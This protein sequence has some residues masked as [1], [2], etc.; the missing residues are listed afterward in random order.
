EVQYFYQNI[1]SE[2]KAP[3]RLEIYNEQ[4]FRDLSKYRMHWTLLRNGEWQ[5]EGT[6]DDVNVAPQDRRLIDV[7]YGDIDGSAEWLLN[8]SFRLKEADGLLE[9]DFEVARQ[10]LALNDF[11]WTMQPLKSASR[12]KIRNNAAHQFTV[13][14]SNFEIDF[15]VDDGSITRWQVGGVSLLKSGETLRPNFWRAPTDNDFGAGL[16]KK[17]AFWKKPKLYYYSLSQYDKNNLQVIIIEYKLEGSDARVLME[18]RVNDQGSM[19]IVE[20]LIPGK[21]RDLPGLF[22]FGV[23]I[24]LPKSFEN[25]EYYGRGPF[26][27]YADRK[28]ASFL[29]RWTQTVSEQYYPYI[30]PQ[31]TG[32]RTDLRW[33]RIT[34]QRGKGLEIQA[35]EPFSASA[36]HYRIETLDDGEFKHNRHSEF[37]KEDDV[38]NLLLDWRQMGLG[39]ITSWGAVPLPEYHL[40]YGEYRFHFIL[41]PI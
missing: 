35:E 36:L 13:S 8:L 41:K 22:R 38:T 20:Q 19:E 14:G 31:E 21:N 40:P 11:V 28:A 23:Q 32:T 15:S 18:Y 2:L 3:N 34:N 12:P 30:K 27:N 24:P 9:K 5:A 26:E 37:L 1:W 25:L 33:L 17:M 16:Q 4:F 29:G 7:P 10:Q 6:V 39:C